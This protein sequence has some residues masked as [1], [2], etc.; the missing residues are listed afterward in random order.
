MALP[1]SGVR[2]LQRGTA[3]DPVRQPQDR[4][5]EDLR[6]WQA[7]A[8]AGVHRAGQ[9]LSVCRPLRQARREQRQRQGR[10]A[11]QVCPGQLHDAGPGGGE[12]RRA[13][14]RAGRVVPCPAERLC[15]KSMPRLLASVWRPIVRYCASCPWLRWNR[16]RSAR[17]GCPRH[18]WSAIATTTTRCRRV[19]GR[20][21]EWVR[22]PSGNPA[23]RRGDGAPPASLWRGG[24][25]RRSATLSGVDQQKP[26]A[27]DQAAALQGWDLPEVFQHLRHLLE[28]RLGNRGTREFIR[29][30]RL[31]EL[32]LLDR[33]RR[34]MERRIRV[35][36]F[37]AVKSL[38]T[39]DFT[40]IPGLDKMLELARCEYILRRENIIASGNSGTGK[41][42]WRWRWA[43]RLTR[44]VS[45]L[46]SPRRPRSATS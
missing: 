46:R 27:L 36:R 26:N 41:T 32:E 28:A 43:L 6:R 21:G 24:F 31:V 12:L 30:L 34:T 35:A 37:P 45:P 25:C 44:G 10:G 22:R 1:G 20:R 4:G 19:S 42:K 29:V 8:D 3:V 9:P 2:V 13:Q 11:G 17:G 7:P 5:G 14:R 40:A 39:F 23:W 38:D 18:R 15:R 16:A 33:E